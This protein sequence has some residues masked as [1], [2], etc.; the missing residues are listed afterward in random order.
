MTLDDAVQTKPQAKA[1]HWRILWISGSC[2]LLS[3]L[4]L[5]I[6]FLVPDKALSRGIIFSL[7]PLLLLPVIPVLHRIFRRTEND[8]SRMALAAGVAGMTP[9]LIEMLLTRILKLAGVEVSYPDLAANFR[10]L[11]AGFT[12]LIGLW[13]AMIGHLGYT[14]KLFPM[15]LSHISIVA[16]VF[17]ILI[18]GNLALST[19]TSFPKLA[20]S[21]L[22]NLGLIVWIASHVVFTGWL[23]I[24]LLSRKRKPAVL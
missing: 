9:I 18:I 14:T 16:G 23:G 21:G 1:V 8:L 6:A 24:W 13:M 11:L 2:A 4:L 19:S 20:L 22:W 15:G 5:V 3:G 7:S 12:I 10:S 17:R